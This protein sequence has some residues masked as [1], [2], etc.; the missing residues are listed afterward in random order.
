MDQEGARVHLDQNLRDILIL[1]NQLYD[2][3]SRAHYRRI[4]RLLHLRELIPP[5]RI[6]ISQYHKDHE[7]VIGSLVDRKALSLRQ[8][9]SVSRIELPVEVVE[10]L[11]RGIVPKQRP[12]PFLQVYMTP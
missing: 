10:L 1:W 9:R 3:I 8:F 5:R 2:L 12:S 6:P 11:Y 7:A 4:M